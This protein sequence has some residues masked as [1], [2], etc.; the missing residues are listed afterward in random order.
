MAGTL[1]EELNRFWIWMGMIPEEFSDLKYFKNSEEDYPHWNDF[2]RA[3]DEAIKSYNDNLDEN[4][5]ND[6]L[7][8]IATDESWG[9][10]M[11]SCWYGTYKLK[12]EARNKMV[13]HGLTY[14]LYQARF[15]IV[16]KIKETSL[17][18]KEQLL[19]D[20][21]END[22]D[23][24]VKRM[25][26]NNLTEMNFQKALPYAERY[27]SGDDEYLRLVSLRILKKADSNLLAQVRERL[28]ADPFSIIRDEINKK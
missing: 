6:L 18:N 3:V 9:D 19:C 23:N 28:E 13:T 27:I 2:N 20:V 10:I 1:R 24:Y 25:A 11:E 12:P 7:E 22:V 4:M 15:Q 17:E 21:I 14:F 5:L 8:A 16:E 26:L